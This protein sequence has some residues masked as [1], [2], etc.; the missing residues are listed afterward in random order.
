MRFLAGADLHLRASTPVNRRDDFIAAQLRKVQYIIN[1]AYED[2]AALAILWGGDVY[3]HHDVPYW[4]VER[5]INVFKA[6]QTYLYDPKELVVF[7]Q[8]DQRFHTSERENTPLGTTLA[9]VEIMDVLWAEPKV[10]EQQGELPVH[11]Y[12]MSWGQ[13]I[14]VVVTDKD[15]INILVAHQM[16]TEQGPLWPGHEGFVKADDFLK[17][18]PEFKY[19][20][21]GDNHQQFTVRYRGRTLINPGSVMRSNIDQVDFEPAFYVID[22]AANT[23]ERVPFPIEPGS[24]VFRLEKVEEEKERN[25]RLEEFIVSLKSDTDDADSLNF[26]KNLTTFMAANPLPVPV[27]DAIQEIMR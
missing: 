2:P 26:R 14:P 6:A 20:V 10:F 11:I 16:T 17:E 25:E 1:Y 15:V 3:D 24:E 4:V 9:G 27:K 22:T 21:T 7:G 12:G 5:Y 13:E 19:V 18:H 23:V 8:H